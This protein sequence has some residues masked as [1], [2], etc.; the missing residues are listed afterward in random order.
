MSAEN[1]K[2]CCNCRSCI[3]SRDEKYNVTVC[4]CEVFKRY[5]SYAEVMASCCKRWAKEN[6]KGDK[7]CK[8]W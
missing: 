3:R 1:G 4:R 2:V 7:K 5:L 8:V 6:E